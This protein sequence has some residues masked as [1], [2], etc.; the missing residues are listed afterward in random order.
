YGNRLAALEAKMTQ[1]QGGRATAQ[2]LVLT[3]AVTPLPEPQS[4]PQQQP[5]APVPTG[6]EG[7][8]GPTGQLP[9]YGGPAGS[10]VFNPDIAAFGKVNTLHNH[11]LPWTD[12]PLVTTNLVG[13]EDGIDDTGFSLAKLI[14]NRWIFLEAT[15]QAFRGD[16]NDLFRSSKRGDLSYVTPARISG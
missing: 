3:T 11:V 6:A 7:A 4:Q 1:I 5:V 15:G 14:P 8:G 2:S 10:K 12:R 16:S 13:G 9:V